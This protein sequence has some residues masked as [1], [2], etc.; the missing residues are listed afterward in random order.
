M[1]ASPL[2]AD[3][4]MCINGAL[5]IYDNWGDVWK[6]CLP[7]R[8][9]SKLY[10]QW[11]N[12]FNSSHKSFSV[13]DQE[14]DKTELGNSVMIEPKVGQESIMHRKVMTSSPLMHCT[15]PLNLLR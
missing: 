13:A 3:E 11:R 7:Y 2:T 4:I 6:F 1:K 15:V 9:P 8:D 12:S 5:R 10:G 14:K